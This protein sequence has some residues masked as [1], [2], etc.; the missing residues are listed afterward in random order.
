M[1]HNISTDLN[2]KTS[3]DYGMSVHSF[4]PVQL[5]NT[6]TNSKV[7]FAAYGGNTCLFSNSMIIIFID[8]GF[9]YCSRL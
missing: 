4:S 9:C 6:N 3:N 1:S 7:H 5:N 8:I 2:R